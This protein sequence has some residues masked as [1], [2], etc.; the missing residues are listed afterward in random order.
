[1]G[2]RHSHVRSDLSNRT[3]VAQREARFFDDLVQTEGEFDPFTSS[4]WDT[5]AR[6]FE[7]FVRPRQG[8]RV[9]DIGC[10][11]GQSRRLYIRYASTYTGVDLAPAALA[12]ARAKF[13]AD[14]WECCDARELPFDEAAFD[15]V[16]FSSVLHHIPDF[17]AALREGL[18]VLVPGGHA[19]AFDPNLLNPVMA[20]FRHP[21]SPLYTS[22]GVSPNEAPLG[23]WTLRE[24][25]RRAG[26]H[27]I[28]QRAQSAI[29]YRRVAPGLLN[30]GLKAFNCVDR[31]FERIG[32]GR[33]FGTFVITAARKP[34]QP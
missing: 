11:T 12:L 6:R 31:C 19:F 17:E 15:L 21:R 26:F 33:W 25:F 29:E 32:F 3:E 4:G 5:I 34:E 1:M 16:C 30:A 23:A 10:G 2:P 28:V 9:L 13:P 14:R 18:R 27:D 7:A 24:G 20:L 8:L 22:A